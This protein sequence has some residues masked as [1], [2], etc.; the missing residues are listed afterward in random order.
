MNVEIRSGVCL[1][2]QYCAI[3]KD[4]RLGNRGYCSLVDGRVEHP[5]HYSILSRGRDAFLPSGA[6][7]KSKNV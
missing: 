1:W 5:G 7:A 2:L 6:H 4:D 3:T